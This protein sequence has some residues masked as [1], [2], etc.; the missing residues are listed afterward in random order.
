M[1]DTRRV[2]LVMISFILA[3]PVVAHAQRGVPQSGFPTWQERMQLVY[4]N[5]ARADPQADL[6]GC[7][8]CAEAACYPNAQIPVAYSYALNRAARF[9]AANLEYANRFQHDS[10]CALVSNLASVY[11]PNGACRG[12]IACSCAGGTLTGTTSTG[13]R[14]SLFAPVSAWGENIATGFSSPRQTFY[15]WLWEPEASATCGFRLS[16]GH[17]YNILEPSRRQL[18]AG[19]FRISRDVWVLDLANGSSPT[20][21]LIAGGH[22]PQ[23]AG[24]TIEFRVNYF[25]TGAPTAGVVNVD[26]TCTAMA[27]ERGSATNAT[28]LATQT[29]TGTTCRNYRFEFVGPSGQTVY[30]P[31]TG[32]YGI[33][34]AG[35]ADW[36]SVVPAACGTPPEPPDQPPTIAM[37]AAASPSSV[38]GTTTS[39]AV[40]GADDDGEPAL[41]YTWAASGPAPVTFSANGTNAAKSVTAT[42]AAAGTYALSVTVRDAA[43][44]TAT[45]S[46]TAT[47]N[48]TVSTLA[49]S[50][51]TASVAASSSVTFARVAY[52]QFANAIASPPAT[53]WSVTGGG[54]IDATGRFT[55][56]ATP[57]GPY[58]VTATVGGV[59]G[60]SQVTVTGPNAPTIAQAATATPSTVSG[61]TTTVTVLGA[62][63]AGE[64]SLAYAWTSAGPAPTTITP[65]GTNA[66]KSVAVTF[67]Q[68]G[69]YTLTAQ[70][71]DAVMQTATS[72]V[73]VT[74][75]AT[76]TSIAVV[77]SAV[78]VVVGERRAFS[79]NVADQFARPMSAASP[80]WSV[81][82]G[83][84]VDSSGAFTAGLAAGGPFTLTASVG[85]ATGTALV[86]ITET[87]DHV[88][89]TVAITSPADGSQVSGIVMLTASANDDVDVA[90]VVFTA[91]TVTVEAS[92]PPWQAPWDTRS[93]GEGRHTIEVRAVDFA[94]NQSAPATISVEVREAANAAGAPTTTGG[95]AAATGRS[96][97]AASSLWIVLVLGLTRRRQCRRPAP[98]RRGSR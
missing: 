32:S 37:A 28:Y 16:N 11:A 93:V 91:G 67:A 61:T 36:S 21:T 77:P 63:G 73:T 46:V 45:S 19:Y 92:S 54:A 8:S 15:Q 5:R 85:G 7:P 86:V 14:L 66:A 33:G 44:L 98:P 56:G 1:G 76:P 89:P 88:A 9:H 84:T 69:T 83:G 82:G 3:L 81:D 22:E 42:F 40:L 38:A 79:A 23:L 30:L 10:P 87:E 57:G 39:L 70:I 2:A 47:V 24:G 68:A 18:G 72:S 65:N 12:E 34:G 20:G 35:C 97:G 43:N 94:G 71:S 27:R 90:K 58:T 64:A 13:A 59:Q 96:D 52:D 17:R 51:P 62:S 26:G 78:A 48:Q 60:T 4:V 55:A 31:E 50:P 74:V 6:S 49:V 41:T 29:V 75:S 80:T 95:C 25:D 53:T